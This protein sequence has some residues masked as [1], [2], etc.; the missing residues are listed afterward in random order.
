[1][2]YQADIN[3]DLGEG[4]GNDRIIMPYI[5]SCN[6]A[7]G[8]HAGN[9]DSMLKTLLLARQHQVRAGAHPSY[10]D[11][12]NFGRKVLRMEK[13]ELLSSLKQQVES[14]LK[15]ANAKGVKIHHLKPHGAL[16]NKAAHDEETACIVTDVA[17][18]YKLILYAPYGSVLERV[19]RNADLTVWSEAFL[20]RNY[21]S[22][23]SLVARTEPAAVIS[24]TEIIVE[25]FLHML[26]KKEVLLAN[27]EKLK[28]NAQTFC[29]HGDEQG[30]PE[31]L[32][33][34]HH[35]LQTLNIKL[36]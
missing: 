29:I 24:D 31:I 7:C 30:T 4:S 2:K 17:A 8:G 21:N 11:R 36:K 1:M 22:D 9:Q 19:G 14:L 23:L 25:R 18:F 32:E 6:I 3:C 16:Y 10:P 27:G 20:D 13:E 28:I 33:V 35:Q 15:I 34:L 5:T 26:Q 12:E